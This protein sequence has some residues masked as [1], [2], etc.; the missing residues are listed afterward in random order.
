VLPELLQ[1]MIARML[2]AK[3]ATF[4]QSLVIPFA[5]LIYNQRDTVL[6]LLENTT[7]QGRSALDVLLQ[8]WC[9]NA[10]TFQGFWAPRVSTLALC[11]LYEASVKRASLQ[12]I[13]VKGDMIIRPEQSDVIMTRSKSKQM[14]TEFASIPFPAKALKIILSDLTTGG[15][16][17]AASFWEGQDL[18]ADDDDDTWEDERPFGTGFKQD[19][20]KFLSEV[21][22]RGMFDDDEGQEGGADDEDLMQDPISQL[23]M[24]ERLLGFLGRR[25]EQDTGYFEETVKHLSRDEVMVVQLALKNQ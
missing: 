16:A 18:E 1:A 24:R 15:E 9:E 4:I 11:A 5:F 12:N 14:P 20:L 21:L 8:T 23:N 25:A 17:A 13:S 2:T 6:D 19:E 7:V 22:D 3:T 10:E